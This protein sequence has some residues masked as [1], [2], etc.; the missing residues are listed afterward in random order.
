MNTM[1]TSV[2]APLDE[3]LAEDLHRTVSLLEQNPVR[4]TSPISTKPK[5]PPRALTE[6]QALQLKALLTYDDQAV[7]RDL[8]ALVSTML[9]SGLR[10]GEAIAVT[11]EAADFEAETIEVRGTVIREKGK[12]LRIKL[13]PKSK[14]GVRKLRLPKWCVELLRERAVSRFVKPD[15]PVFP[16]PLGGLRDPSNTAADIKDAFEKADFGWATSH[17]LR[18][19]TATLLDRGGLTAREIADQ[20][21]HAN[22]SMTHDRYGCSTLILDLAHIS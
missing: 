12:G 21:G 19:T 20:L 8:P 13:A 7:A 16:A 17:T 22:P 3:D 5:N 11:W 18:K 4:E 10:L 14:A 9:A 2:R 15:D 1:N 6:P